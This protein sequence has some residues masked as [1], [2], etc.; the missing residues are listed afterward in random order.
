M[1]MCDC[2]QG[3]LPCACKITGLNSPSGSFQFGGPVEFAGDRRFCSD[4]YNKER[5]SESYRATAAQILI[6][7]RAT[8]I[9]EHCA[10]VE[11]ELDHLKTLHLGDQAEL[12][13][14]RSQFRGA[15]RARRIYQILA[16]LGWAAA[17]AMGVFL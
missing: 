2:N 10:R 5:E 8:P 14:A 12:S 1:K 11:R 7:E 4:R 13:I 9:F 15:A 6:Q 17:V 16:L 3:R